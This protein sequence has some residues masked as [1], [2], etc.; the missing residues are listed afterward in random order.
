MTGGDGDARLP[1]AVI[2]W[3][4]R[5]TARGSRP[6]LGF[7]GRQIALRRRLR[8]DAEPDR[9]VDPD[10]FQ[11]RRPGFERRPAVFVLDDELGEAD[12]GCARAWVKNWP[13]GLSGEHWVP[14]LQVPAC[15]PSAALGGLFCGAMMSPVSAAA[16][17]G[18]G[19][20]RQAE[21]R[22]PLRSTILA[23]AGVY[24]S[25]VCSQSA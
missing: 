18:R 19:D 23:M 12:G 8:V 5:P 14:L 20:Q 3:R 4:R 16:T 10:V 1:A 21:G 9:Q 6:A 11:R 15:Q 25:A 24:P 7:E 17:A 22:Q 13:C 2:S